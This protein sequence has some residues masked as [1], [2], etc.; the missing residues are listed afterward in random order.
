MTVRGKERSG[1]SDLGIWNS[2]CQGHDPEKDS[3]LFRDQKEV[4]YFW[5]GFMRGVENSR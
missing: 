1:E 2:V 4:Q 5:R 3:G